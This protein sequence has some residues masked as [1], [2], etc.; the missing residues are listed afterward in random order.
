MKLTR[1]NGKP[2]RPGNRAM[3]VAERAHVT[4]VKLAPCVCCEQIPEFKRPSDA[5]PATLPMSEAHHLL[6]GGIRIGHAATVPLCPYHHRD[7][8]IVTDWDRA[9]HRRRL[10]PS[11]E[12]GSVPFHQR[13]G[14]DAA[15]QRQFTGETE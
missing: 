3:T 1:A 12:A 5:D 2:R 14:D 9:E 11:L 8:L 6:S 4:A 13:F 10:G 7:R 15:L